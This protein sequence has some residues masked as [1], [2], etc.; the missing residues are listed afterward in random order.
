[1]IGAFFVVSPLL[2]DILQS[3]AASNSSR[4]QVVPGRSHCHPTRARIIY[5]SHKSKGSPDWILPPSHPDGVRCGVRVLVC[6]LSNSSLQ[7]SASGVQIK[8]QIAGGYSRRTAGRFASRPDHHQAEKMPL[9]AN[10]TS[11][12]PGPALE[13]RVNFVI[14]RDV[15][16]NVRRSSGLVIIIVLRAYYIFTQED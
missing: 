6:S 5:T 4:G 15:F 2:V 3:P 8:R 1:M 16:A 12:L 7:A 10:L 11:R 13:R 9:C 14:D